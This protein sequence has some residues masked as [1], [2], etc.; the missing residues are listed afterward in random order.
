MGNST[1]DIKCV[2]LIFVFVIESNKFKTVAKI[3]ILLRQTYKNRDLIIIIYNN[4][5]H[6]NFT[7]IIFKCFTKQKKIMYSFLL[8]EMY[9]FCCLCLCRLCDTNTILVKFFMLILFKN[10]IHLAKVIGIFI[11][12]VSF[13]YYHTPS[14]TSHVIV[15]LTQRREMERDRERVRKKEKQLHKI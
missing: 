1:C 7:R 15:F 5:F 2:Y 9:I 11:H 4:T 12:F 10:V 8:F 14:H 13:R 6:N 3:I